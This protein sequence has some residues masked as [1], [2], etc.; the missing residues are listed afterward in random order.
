[1][2]RP[3]RGVRLKHLNRSGTWPSGNPRFYYRPIGQ[4]GIAMPDLPADDPKFLR[5]YAEAAERETRAAGG[6]GS[7]DAVI[8]AFLSGDHY[9]TR[10][11]STRSVWRRYLDDVRKRYGTALMVDLGSRHIRQDLA[12][13]GAHEANNRL[14]AWRALCKWAVN[15]GMLDSDPAKDVRKRAAPQTEGHTP[16]TREDVAAFRAKWPIGTAQRLA[17]EIM[18]HTGAAV[19]DAIKMG[20]HNVKDGWITYTRQ[21]SKTIA[22]SPFADG[23]DWF[24]PSD[25]LGRCLDARKTR[26]LVWL[27]TAGGRPR[28]AKSV[29]QWFSSACRDAGIS[30][31]AHGIRKH[32]AAVMREN[33]A[34][35][36]QRM[37]V[38]G[39]D[40]ATQERAYSKG[41]DLRRI[42]ARTETSNSISNFKKSDVK[43]DS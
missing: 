10:A 13:F 14:K 19:I 34:T 26:H 27:T 17:F 25:M 2:R 20:D 31:T 11:P 8:T 21:K 24:E 38:L 9:K 37:A 29:S 12:R 15:V 41:A 16:W 23:P 39:H 33:G 36:D 1:M 42:I 3:I 4:K 35:P 22:A 5:A 28:S 30:K 18:H 32:R 7:I 43:S 40:T 6:K